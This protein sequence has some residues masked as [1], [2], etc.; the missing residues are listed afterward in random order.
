M[1]EESALK[2][3]IPEVILK[4]CLIDLCSYLFV[5]MYT[6]AI[7]CVLDRILWKIIH[8]QMI[9]MMDIFSNSKFM[10]FQS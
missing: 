8:S 5:S 2:Y 9:D 7:N 6:E 3:S 10:S 4:L 1:N